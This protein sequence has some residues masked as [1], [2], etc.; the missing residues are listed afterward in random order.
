[1]V[2]GLN[3]NFCEL[4]KIWLGDYLP[5]MSSDS[6]MKINYYL[7]QW[8]LRTHYMCRKKKGHYTSEWILTRACK[9]KEWTL[10]KILSGVN[11]RSTKPQSPPSICWPT[12]D[13]FNVQPFSPYFRKWI[14]EN[15]ILKLTNMV[16]RYDEI[17]W[18][19]NLLPL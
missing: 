10:H 18:C 1:M 5:C 8:I 17:V 9:F 13:I 12:D 16:T 4:E 15:D 3:P 7:R 11:P 19:P 14:E 6:L 2:K